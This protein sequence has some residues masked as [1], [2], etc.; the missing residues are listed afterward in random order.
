MDKTTNAEKSILTSFL[1]IGMDV[2]LRQNTF[3]Q[4]PPLFGIPNG[5]RRFVA[6][7]FEG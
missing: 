3:I 1:N 2:D 5:E 7:T 4:H 6:R